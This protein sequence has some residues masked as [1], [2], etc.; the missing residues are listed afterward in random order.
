M[1]KASWL[2]YSAPEMEP[3]PMSEA[4]PSPAMTMMFGYGPG[5]RPFLISASYPAAMPAVNDPPLAIGGCAPGTGDGG[6]RKVA[7]PPYMQPGGPAPTVA[8][9]GALS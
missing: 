7:V 2:R 3:S 4:L 5:W 8:R 6:H 9:A 1:N